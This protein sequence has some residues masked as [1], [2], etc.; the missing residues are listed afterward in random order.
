MQ[1]LLTMQRLTSVSLRR[2]QTSI[3]VCLKLSTAKPCSPHA[4]AKPRSS[5]AAAN[6]HGRSTCHTQPPLPPSDTQDGLYEI[7]N[8]IECVHDSVDYIWRSDSRHKVFT[9]IVKQ[10]TF[11][12]MKLFDDCKI[13]TLYGLYFKYVS[14]CSVESNASGQGS[15]SC[16]QEEKKPVPIILPIEDDASKG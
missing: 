11:R 5:R 15:T 7:K 6:H 1:R 2:R 4:A 14:M 3:S 13:R 16:Q 8:V 12:D 10:L 9:E